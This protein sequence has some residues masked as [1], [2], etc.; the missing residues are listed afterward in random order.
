MKEY[1]KS[2]DFYQS[3]MGLPD[4]Q[5]VIDVLEKKIE[6]LHTDEGMNSLSDKSKLEQVCKTIKDSIEQLDGLIED[7]EDEELDLVAEPEDE[8]VGQQFVRTGRRR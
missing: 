3:G 2:T 5:M 1:L 4:L 7:L 8:D 6:W